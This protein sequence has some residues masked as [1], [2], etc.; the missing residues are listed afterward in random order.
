MQRTNFFYGL[1]FAMLKSKVKF[2]SNF[3]CKL[4]I[5][6]KRFFSRMSVYI[7]DMKHFI[8]I[9]GLIETKN[10]NV[11][12]VQ[13]RL[14]LNPWPYA[15]VSRLWTKLKNIFFECLIKISNNLSS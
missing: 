13:I 3:F 5:L 1:N 2:L 11:D 9:R 8:D 6:R 4:R 12:S 7:I 15:R 14:G 10:T